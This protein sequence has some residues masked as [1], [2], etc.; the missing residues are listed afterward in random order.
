MASTSYERI[1]ARYEKE[2]GGDRRA[3]SITAAIRP[4]LNPGEP[5]LDIGAGTG[6]VAK[7]LVEGGIPVI[8]VDISFG[9]LSQAHNRLPGR[10]LLAD[11]QK[12]PFTGQYFD[13]VTFVWSL[14]HIGDPVAAVREARRVLRADGRVVVVSA[15]PENVPDDVQALFRRLDSLSPMRPPDWIERTARGAGL[16]LTARAQIEIGVERSPLELVRQIEERLYAPLWDLDDER[17]SAVVDPILDELRSLDGPNRKRH[18]TLRSPVL[19]FM[20]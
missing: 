16:N 10:V 4:W 2:R 19:T 15:T 12:V 8:G 5:V 13:A 1:S 9:M 20:P 7:I 17:W 11:A 3:T 6:I 14:Q 18:S